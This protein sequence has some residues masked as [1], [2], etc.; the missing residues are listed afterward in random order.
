MEGRI[1]F[2]S[3]GK[4]DDHSACCLTESKLAEIYLAHDILLGQKV[5]IKLEPIEGG[6]RTLK[7]EINVYSKLG[8]GTGIP[9]VYWFGRESGFNAMVISHLGQSLDDLFVQCRFRFS[10]DTVH[11]LASQLVRIVTCHVKKSTTNMHVK[12]LSPAIYPLP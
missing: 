6:H 1:G 8:R 9:H 10:V 12:D 5:A 4:S 11:K 7:N 3:H 2:G